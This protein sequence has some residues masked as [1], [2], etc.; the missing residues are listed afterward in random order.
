MNRAAKRS[1]P[2]QVGKALYRDQRGGSEYI[3]YLVLK[4]R[5]LVFTFSCPKDMREDWQPTA[6]EIMKNLRVR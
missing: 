1:S 2:T 4:D 5:T 3:Q 6:H